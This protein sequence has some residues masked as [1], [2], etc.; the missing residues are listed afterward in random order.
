MIFEHMFIGHAKIR[1]LVARHSIDS[2]TDL[3]CV[4]LAYEL[5]HWTISASGFIPEF[6]GLVRYVYSD[7]ETAECQLR[8]V[9]AEFAAFVVEDV[10]GL[11]GWSMLL[12]EVRDFATNLVKQTTKSNGLI[13]EYLTRRHV[14]IASG[15]RFVG[16]HLAAEKEGFESTR[17]K[18]RPG[19]QPSVWQIRES[20]LFFV[21]TA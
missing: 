14:G 15:S 16:H 2:L 11:E 9:V 12:N 17:R 18:A 13:G 4:K 19:I 20:P 21:P 5:A 8:Q 7:R 6:R 3:S 1:A 10:R